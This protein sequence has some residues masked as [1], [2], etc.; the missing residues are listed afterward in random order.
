MTDRIISTVIDRQT[1]ITL[2]PDTSVRHAAIVMAENRIG[3]IPVVDGDRLLGIFSERDL[4]G[5][6]VAHGLDTD[7]TTIGQMMTPTPITVAS[8]RPMTHAL[9]IMHESGFRHLPVVDHGKVV[10]MVSARD[11]QPFE[12]ADFGDTVPFRES[13][14][15]NLR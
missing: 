3:A 1:I 14:L 12:L 8:H 9:H 6:V 13:V 5:R 15:E 2:G 10:G 11:A 7:A 4:M